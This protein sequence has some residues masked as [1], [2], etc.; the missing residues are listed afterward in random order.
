MQRIFD[1]VLED[2]MKQDHTPILSYTIHYPEFTTDCNQQA[3]EKINRYY[4]QQARTLEEYCRNK[5][6]H[7]AVSELEFDEKNHFPAITYEVLVE[8][9]VTFNQRCITSL[10]T[11]QYMFTGGAHGTT[12]RRGDTWDFQN[13]SRIPVSAFYP[14]GADFRS[15]ILKVVNAQIRERLKKMPGTYFDDYEKLTDENWNARD[16]YVTPDGLV[17]FFQQYEVAPYST[18]MPRFFLPFEKRGRRKGC[19]DC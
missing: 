16:F 10:F 5:L 9:A 8:Y 11:D 12:I 13:G 2:T 4:E 17:V 18:G 15:C 14:P 1:H 3:A 19:S 7:D 6:F